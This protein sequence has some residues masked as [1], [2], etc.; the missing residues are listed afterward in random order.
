MHGALANSIVF[1]VSLA[2]RCKDES[3]RGVE[4]EAN[5]DRRETPAN[6]RYDRKDEDARRSYSPRR[7]GERGGGEEGDEKNSFST[8]AIVSPRG[9]TECCKNNGARPNR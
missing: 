1:I 4:M 5:D 2:S 8:R 9:L 3:D 7:R 6:D